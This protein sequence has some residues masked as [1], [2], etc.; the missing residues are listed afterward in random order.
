MTAGAVSSVGVTFKNTGSLA[1][2]AGGIAPVRLSYHWRYGACPGGSV[3][4][5]EGELTSLPRS[6]YPGGTVSYLLAR[7]KAPAKA[8][9]YC[10]E[11]DLV[12][13]AG[14]WFSAQGAATLRRTVSVT[15]PNLVPRTAAFPWSTSASTCAPTP[16]P[17]ARP[18]PTRTATSAPTATMTPT[19]TRTPT[20]A[21]TRTTTPAA[22]S[23]PTPTATPVSG[24]SL[25]AGLPRHLSI[26]LMSSPEQLGWMTGSGIPW[27]YR[28]QYLTGGVNTGSGWT[29]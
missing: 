2:R 11:Y 9:T 17:T 26:G 1:W 18:T 19:P 3:A 14:A 21:P 5:W 20:V 24:P 23:T 15:C 25:P 22:T 8:G 6:I 10:I 4:V 13:S 7:V 29:N 27:D 16:L 12:G 28:Y